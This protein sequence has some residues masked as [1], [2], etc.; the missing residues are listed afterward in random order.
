VVAA[1]PGHD[2]AISSAVWAEPA[3]DFDQS[4][5]LCLVFPELGGAGHDGSAE[6]A[7][8]ALLT[9]LADEAC[10]WTSLV[11]VLEPDA[12]ALEVGGSLRLFGGLQALRA[13]L[14]QTL[15]AHGYSVVA[16]C[17]P[18]ARAAYW[19][20][21]AGQ[22][23]AC[24]DTRQLPSQ[25]GGLLLHELGWPAAT[26]IKLRQMG[27]RNLAECRRL[28]RAGFARR[29]GVGYLQELDQAFGRMPEL[30]RWHQQPHEFQRHIELPDGT[31]SA[32]Q[33]LLYGKHLLES[34]G[35]FLRQRQAVAEQL[36]FS[37]EHRELPPTQFTLALSGPCTQTGY[38]AELLSLRLDRT[39]LKAPVT[40]LIL[41]AVALPQCAPANAATRS[42]PGMTEPHS[43]EQSSQ[44]QRL[45]ERLQA[46]LGQACVYGLRAVAEHRP[47]YAWRP[48]AV[49]AAAGTAQLT[50]LYRQ[51]R[52]LWLLRQPRLMALTPAA[53]PIEHIERVEAGWWDS[54]DVSR[55]YR[56]VRGPYGSAWWVYRDRRE[57]RWYLHGVF[58]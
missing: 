25:L 33:I 45:V 54:R 13:G 9:R 7:S 52:P 31:E 34:L 8:R 11:S 30:L 35:A 57:A 55:D 49:S 41:T 17:A 18:T 1:E 27:V 29:V 24:L 26:V 3:A 58:G 19:L 23:Q 56:I 6:S 42:L 21:K 2:A 16:A 12:L 43:A 47:E 50:G 10:V 4:L 38:L 48:A 32:Q 28:P 53:A 51:P 36:H 46:R 5:W 37:L 14:L 15:Q 20:A 22:A 39:A 40:G 44:T